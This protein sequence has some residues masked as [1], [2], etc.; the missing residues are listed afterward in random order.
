MKSAIVTGSAKGLGKAI[1]LM[2]AKEG[3]A[4]VLG[5]NKSAKEAAKT[6]SELRKFNPDCIAV[7][8]DLTKEKDVARLMSSAKRKFGRIDVLVNNIGDFLYKPLLKTSPEEIQTVFNS[9]VITA[10]TCSKKAAEVMR[11]QKYGRIINVGSTGCDKLIAPEMT[12]PYYMAKTS[13][14][15]MTKA[16][17]RVVPPGITVNVVCPGILKT[18]V[19]RVKGVK[20]TTFDEVSAAVKKLIKGRL[21]GKAVTVAK[22]KPEG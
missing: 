17:A 7:R 19:V 4:V 2:L 1:A 10:F 5:Y 11:R 3:Y 15:L 12:T 22:W 20:L 16:L 8:G 9:N 14:L 6:L 13:L 21:N 18:S